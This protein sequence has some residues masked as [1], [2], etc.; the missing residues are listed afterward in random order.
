MPASA[1]RFTLLLGALVGALQLAGTLAVYA[2]GQHASPVD[3]AAGHRFENIASFAAI[4]ACMTLGLRSARRSRIASGEAFTFGVGARLSLG[5]ASAGGLF[6]AAGQYAYV[7][8]IHP[9]YA[10]HLR[11]ALVSGAGL[12]PEQAEAAAHQLDFAT[13]PVFR[14]LSHGITTLLFSLMIGV[15]FSFL[16]RDRPAESAPVPPRAG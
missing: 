10:Q 9:A 3:L 5:V 8:F 13:S 16:F 1:F 2:A 15:A 6:T 12:S 11:A 4:M 7:A 14:G